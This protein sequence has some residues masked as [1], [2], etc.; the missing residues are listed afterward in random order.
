MIYTYTVDLP[1]SVPEQNRREFFRLPRSI[2]LPPYLL[3]NPYFVEY[4]DAIDVVFDTPIESKIEAIRNIRNMW[5][6]SKFTELAIQEQKMVEFVDWGG[7]DR[8]TVVAQV[9][10]LGLKLAT[11]NLVDE[12]SYRTLSR[13]LG[14]YWFGKGKE[15][16]I[17]FMNFCLKTDFEIS[18]LW[19]TD[20]K[21]FVPEGDTEIGATIYDSPPGPW[22]PTT[23]VR[24]SVPAGYSVDP[25]TIANFFYEIANYNLV[26]E[27]L[28]AYYDANI[29]SHDS[30]THAKIVAVAGEE[31]T[32][33][34][35]ASDHFDIPITSHGSDRFTLVDAAMIN[36]EIFNLEDKVD[37]L[38]YPFVMTSFN[39]NSNVLLDAGV[40][41]T[42]V[43]NL[44][45]TPITL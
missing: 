38:I 22:Y 29:V 4:V 10:L 26:L 20:Y 30:S 2:L 44:A 11:A 16:T 18:K 24:I 3:I 6:S 23:H 15:T 34:T 8:A 45:T 39:S 25:I 41:G 13:F 14:M 19:T 43:F 27:L 9:N 36:Y 28:Q 17:D 40:V 35:F 37:E 12:N 33:Y 7:P 32:T 31:V 5:I 1:Y 21:H 42:H